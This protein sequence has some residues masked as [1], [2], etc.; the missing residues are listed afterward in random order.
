M[1]LFTTIAVFLP[2]AITAA[3]SALSTRAGDELCAPTSYTLSDYVLVTSNASASV[4]FKFESEFALN[5]PAEDL[6]Q[7]GLT[8]DASGPVIPNNNECTAAG[9][10][11]RELLFDL[12]AP[13]DQS[14]YQISHTWRCNG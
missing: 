14:H 9:G 7:N 5:A 8:C 4:S 2:A 3:P 11:T 6:V 1:K 10:K 13:Q 12:R